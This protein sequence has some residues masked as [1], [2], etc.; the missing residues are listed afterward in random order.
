MDQPIFKIMNEIII[1]ILCFRN[2][3]FSHEQADAI[4]EL[5]TYYDW[6]YT[7][8]LFSEGNYGEN[9]GKQVERAAARL[10]IC[11]AYSAMLR[12]DITNY[13]YNNVVQRLKRAGA[14][15]VI[16][17]LD[18][19]Q[20]MALL[21][22]EDIAIGEFIFITSDAFA[23]RAFS[24]N[25]DGAINVFYPF[26]ERSDFTERIRKM[27]PVNT[28]SNPWF[29]DIWQQHYNCSYKTTS[30]LQ[31]CR[32]LQNLTLPSEGVDKWIATT[33]D[34]FNTV[35]YAL[36]KLIRDICPSGFLD[37][38]ILEDCV[39][40]PD[41]LRYMKNISF[42]GTSWPIEF[43]EN[44][45]VKGRYL[46]QQY[47][48]HGD[49]L[50]TPVGVWDKIQETI[51]LNTTAIDWSLFWPSKSSREVKSSVPDSV[52]SYPCPEKFYKQ[53]RELVCC[54]DCLSCR[55]NEIL[56]LNKTGCSKCPLLEWPDEETAT[57]CISI[58][59]E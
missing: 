12:S 11:I 47:F 35:I 36:D 15:V 21:S 29:I 57:E 33:F 22:H 24:V 31:D 3:C 44:G 49:N 45:D 1:I 53:Q 2:I 37:P 4:V 54:W 38:S 5:L 43:D 28:A 58:E 16:L 19:I 25:L 39:K 30:N 26:R 48:T 55:N 14:R 18:K 42:M 27:T 13:E 59:P 8:L 34:G 40:G 56:N 6:T 51:K 20:G 7:S 10:G 46:F 9:G 41:L 50:E 52:C 23:N 17:F 32:Q